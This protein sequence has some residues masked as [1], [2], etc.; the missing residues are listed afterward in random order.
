[1]FLCDV[2]WA[3]L[4]TSF[5][6]VAMLNIVKGMLGWVQRSGQQDLQWVCFTHL[7]LVSPCSHAG[8][9]LSMSVFA[10]PSLQ[11]HRYFSD[12]VCT[13]LTVLSSVCLHACSYTEE[14]VVSTDFVSDPASSTVD[15]KAGIMLSPTFVKLVSW[16]DNEWGYCE[17]TA[18]L[19]A[20]FSVETLRYVVPTCLINWLPVLS[21]AEHAALLPAMR[22]Y[23]RCSH[24]VCRFD[25]LDDWR[26]RLSARV[27]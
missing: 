15:A 21:S 20:I 22:G 5:E 18:G 16:Y 1:M 25:C 14:A 4:L 3:W 27:V 2:L 13:R 26:H 7:F 12:P 23:Q 17:Y 8:S 19:Y 24:A 11:L 10:H 9:C 6:G